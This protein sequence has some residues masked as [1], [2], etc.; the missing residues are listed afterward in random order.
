MEPKLTLKAA[1]INKNL[2]QKEAAQLIGISEETLS[3][4]ER[5]KSFPDVPILKRIEKVYGVGYNSLIFLAD[6]YG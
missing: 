1:R 2:S 5:A 4:Y 6:D 3:N